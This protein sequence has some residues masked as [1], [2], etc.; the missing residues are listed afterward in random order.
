V[1][2]AVWSAVICGVALLLAGGAHAQTPEPIGVVLCVPASVSG[3]VAALNEGVPRHTVTLL[4]RT[5]GIVGTYRAQ[6]EILSI[7]PRAAAPGEPIEIRLPSGWANVILEMNPNSE[8]V[9]IATSSSFVTVRA[10]QSDQSVVLA[11]TRFLMIPLDALF[12]V[13]QLNPGR[14]LTLLHSCQ[15]AIANAP[16]MVAV[17][18]MDQTQAAGLQV[19]QVVLPLALVL[20]TN[21]RIVRTGTPGGIA[22]IDVR[23]RPN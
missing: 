20:N 2:R 18:S 1:K 21:L 22:V 19:P 14:T 6:A 17:V 4:H 11:R 8:L 7:R 13:R 16:L 5:Q 15:L 9:P 23:E 12:A 10:L 3:E